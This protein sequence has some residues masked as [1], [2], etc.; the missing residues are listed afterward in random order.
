MNKQKRKLA[1]AT[2]AAAAFM[3]AAPKSADGQNVYNP[4]FTARHVIVAPVI[5]SP[6]QWTI[7]NLTLSKPT[8]SSLPTLTPTLAA[9]TLRTPL[10]ETAL[11]SVAVPNIAPNPVA[12]VSV[13]APH[14][15]FA[16]D[17]SIVPVPVAS[18]NTAAPADQQR[19]LNVMFDNSR[20]FNSL[21]D[22]SDLEQAVR[23]QAA[24]ADRLRQHI[25]AENAKRT[26]S[27]PIQ[28]SRGQPIESNDYTMSLEEIR[29]TSDGLGEAHITVSSK[30]SKE[31]VDMH[32]KNGESK[33]FPIVNI[34]ERWQKVFSVKIV[35][36]N[37][38]SGTASIEVQLMAETEIYTLQPNQSQ[39]N[40]QEE[41]NLGKTKN[42]AVGDYVD[43]T[44]FWAKLERI[45]EDGTA[46]FHIVSGESEGQFD[47][48][49]LQ[50]KHLTI[51]VDGYG[52][53]FKVSFLGI[54]QKDG[55]K[56]VEIVISED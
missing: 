41:D 5:T 25:A 53:S 56:S 52:R 1:I 4:A 24:E 8:L 36:L 34:K 42:I 54:S 9:P 10:I 16:R 13:V 14:I 46:S 12:A 3:T 55:K 23:G 33:L 50:K 2:A 45:S 22:F 21:D 20:E 49:P 6:T 38:P 18:I 39:Q 17:A 29:S 47:I 51:E 15:S 48:R 28:L 44:Y 7:N 40:Q 19:R 26:K 27:E 37:N 31:K 11:P 32:V 30:H 43:F 35:D